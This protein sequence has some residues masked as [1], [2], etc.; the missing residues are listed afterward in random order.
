M[1]AFPSH[2]RN[3]IA[4]TIA[5]FPAVQSATAATHPSG[6]EITVVGRSKS[7]REIVAEVAFEFDL[8]VERVTP[9]DSALVFILADATIPPTERPAIFHPDIAVHYV[10]SR[11]TQEPNFCRT[12]S[13]KRNN[14]TSTK[15]YVTCEK[16]RARMAEVVSSKILSDLLGHLYRY[17]VLRGGKIV[18]VPFPE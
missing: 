6:M 13:G 17:D 2:R 16:C 8:S 18:E 14:A 15:K 9:V 12:R 11:H 1:T 5:N 3:D 10:T 4:E 7:V